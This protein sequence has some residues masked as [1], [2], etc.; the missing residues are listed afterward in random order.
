MSTLPPL[1]PGKSLSLSCEIQRE[2]F[3]HVQSVTCRGPD[4][5]LYSGTKNIPK[6]KYS[7]SVSQ[8]SSIHSGKWT[9]EVNYGARA[10]LHAKTDVVIV[11]KC[12]INGTQ[13]H[14]FSSKCIHLHS[15]A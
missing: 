10:T 1:L 8:V 9:C 7:L 12:R 2:V 13:C 15:G 3:A 14:H 6:N 11:G 5:K 4:N